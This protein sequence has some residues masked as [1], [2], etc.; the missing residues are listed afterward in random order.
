MY[1]VIPAELTQNAVQLVVCFVTVLG[2]MF[3]LM[4]CGRAIR[5]ASDLGLN[6][7]R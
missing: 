2:T 4:L 7:A 3:G 1:P 6:S 5:Q